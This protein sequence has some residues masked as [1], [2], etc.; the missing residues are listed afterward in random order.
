MRTIVITGATSGVGRALVYAFA[1]LGDAVIAIGRNE[2]R[3]N[4]LLTSL[5]EAYKTHHVKILT[6][7]F[8]SL[9][10]IADAIKT[11]ES[12]M[13]TEG[14]DALIHNA[15]IVPRKKKRTK[16]GFELQYQVNHLAVVFLTL[17]LRALVEKRH[18]TVIITG[19]Q[20]HQRA[21]FDDND[22]QA[23]KRY[24]PFRSYCR[25]K[26]YNLMFTHFARRRLSN[27]TIRYVCVHPGRVKTEIGTKD[28]TK[29]YALFWKFFTRKG[30]HPDETVP[31]YLKLVK[32]KAIPEPYYYLGKP[33]KG[34]PLAE[35]AK[36]QAKLFQTALKELKAYL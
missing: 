22:L 11:L 19:S 28:T 34:K 23:I 2:D 10:A 12:S 17:K 9:Q 7:D 36:K 20:A 15:A 33:L 6:A 5:N 29:L 21:R 27:N 32:A 31:T 4:E 3:L 25:T 1:K 8:A 16:D 30:A 13:A 24:H 18:G 35:D 14:I 26:L